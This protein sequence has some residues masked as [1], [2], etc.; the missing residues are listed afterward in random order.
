MA[1]YVVE[2]K[3]ITKTFPGVIANQD[4]NLQVA[5]GEIHALLGE[6]GAGKST[7][8]S[9]LTG[10]YRPDCGQVMIN[11]AKVEFSSPKDAIR[12]GIG[13]VHQHFKLVAP[14]TVWEN[15]ALGRPHIPFVLSKKDII[16]EIDALSKQYGLAIDPEARIWQLSVGEQQRVE[17]IKMLY[18]GADILILDEPTAVLTPQEVVELFSTLEKMTEQGKTVIFIT[19]KLNE[20]MRFAQ[21]ITVLRNGRWIITIDKKE[22]TNS[23]LANLMVGREIILDKIEC[24]RPRGEVVLSVDKLV[25]FNDKGHKALQEMSFNVHS[26]EILAIAGVAGNGQR[27]LAEAIS[28]L[29]PIVSGRII[30][31]NQELTNKGSKAAISAGIS[32]VPEDRL[33]MGLIPNLNAVENIML[34]GY[35]QSSKGFKISID[36][37]YWK[38]LTTKLVGEFN[39]KLTS[40][41]SPVKL[42]SGGNL[43]KLLLAREFSVEPKVIVAVY[44]VRGLDISAIEAVHQLLDEQRNR[45]AAII[46]ISEDLEE[47]FRLADRAMVMYEGRNMG[48]LDK[49]EM[50]RQRIGLMMA[51]AIEEVAS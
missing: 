13:M 31:D 18:G 36:F 5:K 14:F 37:S 16:K 4:V 41:E 19:H 42:M 21:K 40:I 32:H 51:G 22:T 24:N 20:V 3:N 9:I 29:R 26:G 17:I 49:C 2:M 34:K 30:L 6:N 27:E 47:I 28:G 7:L 12:A 43:Q 35:S 44:P 8:M 50:E 46:L 48:I 45:G 11:G 39:I 33:G 38:E 10:L 1:Q 15:V 25:A 23:H